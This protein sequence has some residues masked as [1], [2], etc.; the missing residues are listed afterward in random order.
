M[1]STIKDDVD[2][3]DIVCF[4]CCAFLVNVCIF[5]NVGI[6]VFLFAFLSDVFC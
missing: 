1:V 2:H 5:L 3:V 6:F 4:L